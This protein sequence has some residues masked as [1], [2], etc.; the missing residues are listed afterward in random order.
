MWKKFVD[1]NDKRERDD[2]GFLV[3]PAP[4]CPACVEEGWPQGFADKI[5]G[6][7]EQWGTGK[8]PDALKRAPNPSGP[9]WASK[10]GSLK[11]PGTS[12]YSGPDDL[13]SGPLHYWEDMRPAGMGVAGFNLLIDACGRVLV[14]FMG[15]IVCWGYEGRVRFQLMPR[16]AGLGNTPALVGSLLYVVEI[17]GKMHC[18][19]LSPEPPVL[20]WSQ[21]FCAA[22]GSDPSA[23]AANEDIVISPGME[24]KPMEGMS[25]VFLTHMYGVDAKSGKLRWKVKLP[26]P[27]LMLVPSIAGDCAVYM[28]SS[29]AVDCIALKD[30]KP[31]WQV[32]GEMGSMTTGGAIV[33]GQTV[34]ATFNKRAKKAFN[35][36][37]GGK[38]ATRAYSLADGSQVWEQLFD[39][40]AN[41]L[42]AVCPKGPGGKA[43]VIV[44]LG[45]SPGAPEQKQGQPTKALGDSWGGRVVALDAQTGEVFWRHDLPQYVAAACAGN[46]AYDETLSSPPPGWVPPT[47]GADGNVYANWNVNGTLYVLKGA[48]GDEVSQHHFGHPMACSPVVAPGM[49]WFQMQVKGLGCFA[50]TPATLE[51]VLRPLELPFTGPDGSGTEHFWPMKSNSPLALG[52]SKF[53]AP[54]DLS[55]PAW[56]FKTPLKIIDD[57]YGNSPIMDAQRNIYMGGNWSDLFIIRPDGT[58]RGSLNVGPYYSTPALE[59]EYLYVSDC[60]GH[61]R[62]F[63]ITTLQLKWC[64]K[65]TDCTA[66]DNYSLTIHQGSIIA[67]GN[68]YAPAGTQWSQYCSGKS[69]YQSGHRMA[70]RLSCETGE[71]LWR[72]DFQ[73]VM[74]FWPNV[75]WNFTPV[76]FEDHVVF[77]CQELGAY[78]FKFSDGSYVWHGQQH[79][80]KMSTGNQCCGS[81][82]LVYI[83]GN[84]HMDPSEGCGPHVNNH[85]GPGAVKCFDIRTGDFRWMKGSQDDRGIHLASNQGP[86]LVPGRDGARDLV[87]APF[88]CNMTGSPSDTSSTKLGE[89]WAGKLQAYDAETGEE[90]WGRQW[91][92]YYRHTHCA[93][94][95]VQDPG[96]T[97]PDSWGGLSV[98][99]TGIV[100][101]HWVDGMIYAVES[102]SGEIVASYDTGNSSNAQILLAPGM[103]VF[104]GGF[105]IFCFRDS[106]QEDEWLEGAKAAGDPRAKAPLLKDTPTPTPDPEPREPWMVWRGP[107]YAEEQTYREGE[108]WLK[109]F[110]K[111]YSKFVEVNE[112]WSKKQ[113]SSGPKKSG[114][115]SSGNGTQWVVVG[116]GDKGIVVRAGKDLKS[117]EAGRLEKGAKIEQVKKEGERV[118]YKKLSG[119]GPEAGWVSLSF[120][121]SPLIQ[122]A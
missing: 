23:L 70:Y 54:R 17:D 112:E 10:L 71:V 32:K 61:M 85:E 107:V 51:K 48:T 2:L 109:E 114:G 15:G 80:G 65:Y 117:E 86:C 3:D 87:V 8:I 49:L 68:Q 84:M 16:N 44:C 29:G 19:D 14:P 57:W 6:E 83:T 25:V 97:W 103:V 113:S 122:P 38:G 12:A 58:L 108:E 39:L 105:G 53:K 55:K 37:Y 5:V 118:Q 96:M 24:D 90:A 27:S 106:E 94:S 30:G 67:P 66:S 56:V 13:S 46:N 22:T 35:A 42:P 100:Y 110:T 88:S 99:S 120:K 98:D 116:G 111:V 89:A 20:K 1:P 76:I 69:W 102:R 63:N 78:C 115:G 95:F 101:A 31:K 28:A 26:M 11:A 52:I 9:I 104:T 73:L 93:G 21:A 60:L 40:E 4:F 18:Y 41:C 74:R 43:A 91:P 36:P 92:G 7:G 45:A 72:I 59:G 79:N 62:C 33:Y 47:V 64:T 77:M 50:H 121:G 75:L 34:I 82:G 119:D 81:N